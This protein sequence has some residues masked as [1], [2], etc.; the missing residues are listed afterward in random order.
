MKTIIKFPKDFKN[1]PHAAVLGATQWTVGTLDKPDEIIIS[2]VGGIDSGLYGNG[3]TSFEMW[4]F[5]EEE[6]KGWLTIEEINE[7]LKNNPI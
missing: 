1:K 4:D 6:P 7:H 2:I 5:R 3:I